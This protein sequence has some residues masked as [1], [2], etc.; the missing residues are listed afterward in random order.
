MVKRLVSIGCLLA[1][2]AIS[3]CQ[4]SGREDKM[5][6]QTTET[7]VVDPAHAPAWPAAPDGAHR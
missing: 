1:I 2:L 3:G 5:F 7:I 4:S 6:P